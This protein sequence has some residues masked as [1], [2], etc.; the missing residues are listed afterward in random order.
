MSL[1]N[2]WALPRAKGVPQGFS[3]TDILA[4]IYLNPIDR[5]LRNAGFSHLRY[6]DDIRIFCSSRLKAKQ[7]LFLLNDLMRKRGLNL[8][9]AKTRIVRADDAQHEIDGVTPLI[10]S[11]QSGLSDEFHKSFFETS[12]VTIA[13]I[14]RFF[15]G[16]STPPRLEVLERAF[17]DNFGS[18]SEKFNKTLL[19]YLLTRLGKAKSKVAVDYA[20]EL[21][22]QRPEETN[23]ALRYLG[24]VGLDKQNMQRMLDYISSN[25]AIYDYQNFEIVAWFTSIGVVPKGLVSLCR[26]WCAD[27][28]RDLWLR[29]SARALLGKEGDQS[30]LEAIESSYDCRLGELECADIVDALLRMEVGRRNSFFGRICSDG[31]LIARAI[32]R[33]RTASTQMTNS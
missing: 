11:I 24:E 10:Q 27:R 20:V 15:E 26:R 6:V 5:A 31:D 14:T 1:L 19:H 21:L 25:E 29:S 4:K 3:A 22:Q 17:A 23:A 13:E 12:S 28:N 33:V 32:K 18:V 16:R 2:K 8:Q 9:S 30:D 7:G